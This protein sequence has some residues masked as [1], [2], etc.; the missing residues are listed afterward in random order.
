MM[1]LLLNVEEAA[2]RLGG[3][4]RWSIYS[5]MSTGRLKKTKIGRRVMI[6]ENDLQD[7]VDRCNPETVA[8]SNDDPRGVNEPNVQ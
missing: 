5:W 2:K 3:V 1:Y 6:A 4:S 8:E 7:F